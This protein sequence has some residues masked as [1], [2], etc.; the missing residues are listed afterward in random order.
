M[1]TTQ[2]SGFTAVFFPPPVRTVYTQIFEVN[3][4]VKKNAGLVQ[5][6]VFVNRRSSEGAVQ[7]RQVLFSP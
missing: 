4:F 1:Q 2:R 5:V 6:S 7:L 3:V